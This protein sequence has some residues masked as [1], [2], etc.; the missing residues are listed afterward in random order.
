MGKKARSASGIQKAAD[1]KVDK[2]SL[3]PPPPPPEEEHGSSKILPAPALPGS[4]FKVLGDEGYDD[5]GVA[6]LSL[7]VDLED[8]VQRRKRG[9]A[10]YFSALKGDLLPRVQ[11]GPLAN[12]PRKDQ[13]VHLAQLLFSEEEN[14]EEQCPSEVYV[15]QVDGEE[16]RAT[17]SHRSDRLANAR[18]ALELSLVL[19][20][21]A[22]TSLS[23]AEICKRRLIFFGKDGAEDSLRCADMAI[24]IAGDG[25]WDRDEVKVECE[26]NPKVDEKYEK[27]ATTPALANPKTLKLLPLR[28]SQLCLRSAL[29][30][31]GNALS[32]LGKEEEARETYEKVFPLLE[33][34]PR[35]ARIDWERHSLYVNIGNTFSRTGDFTL[36]DEHFKFA[37]Q[38]GKDHL[39][40]DGGS[41]TDGKAMVAVAKRARAF[42]LKKAGREEEGKAVLRE[43]V[44]QKLKD[45][46]EA[47]MEKN[48]ATKST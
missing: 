42:A 23:L 31:R 22:C 37:E 24:E 18:T 6:D 32:A 33:S 34:E 20:E 38:L 28:V 7:L 26:E 16:D 47:E 21:S 27:N 1:R 45:R 19:G 40:Q 12:M 25:F 44:T 14:S 10:E 41:I 36:A 35:C 9:D 3:P 48:N 13:K 46:M 11:T 17:V 29:L 5:G 43:V 30:Q 15:D 4:G 8:S 39:E 2:S